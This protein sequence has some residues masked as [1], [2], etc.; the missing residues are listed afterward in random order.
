MVRLRAEF[1]GDIENISPVTDYKTAV[2]RFEVLCE[3]CGKTCF[4]DEATREE[5]ARAAEHDHEKTFICPECEQIYE[6]TAG[7]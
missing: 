6:E 3:N 4:V 7:A 5:W 1:E 2:N